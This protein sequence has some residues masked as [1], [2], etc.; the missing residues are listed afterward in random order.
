MSDHASRPALELTAESPEMRE[1][2]RLQALAA[3][4]VSTATWRQKIATTGKKQVI[5]H[6]DEETA[7]LIAATM[8][9][10]RLPSRS[11]ALELLLRPIVRK[12]RARGAGDSSVKP[13][14]TGMPE[15]AV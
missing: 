6:V 1:E 10:N 8:I 11:A 3:H 13:T 15:S 14:Q 5:V 12:S 4:R 7:D 2:R 9:K